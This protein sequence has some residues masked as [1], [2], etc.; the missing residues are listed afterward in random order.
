MVDS[1]ESRPRAWI[2]GS[3]SL[4]HQP[5]TA[6]ANTRSCSPLERRPYATAY[7]HPADDRYAELRR[8]G[9]LGRGIERPRGPDPYPRPTGPPPSLEDLRGRREEIEQVLA[10][11]GAPTLWIFGSVARGEA[12][13]DS[14]LDVLVDFA[15]SASTFEQAALQRA[16]EDLLACPVHVMTTTGLSVARLHTRERIEREA[17]RL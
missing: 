13:P 5:S 8:L 14:D 15:A 17:I 9:E 11:H 2:H 3:D 6:R 4:I 10:A 7:E 1:G 16:L 12:R